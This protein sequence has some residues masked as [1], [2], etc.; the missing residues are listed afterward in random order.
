M[1]SSSAI[2]PDQDCDET[3]F[4]TWNCDALQFPVLL[5]VPHAGR[6]YPGAILSALRI[7]PT[8]LIRLEDR[9]ADRLA[10]PAIK[11]GFPAIIARRARAWIDLNRDESDLDPEMVEGWSLPKGHQGSAKMRGGLGLVP[12]RLSSFGEIWRR[13]FAKADIDE[14][15]SKY[16]RPYHCCIERILN[17]MHARFGV[18]ILI[19]LHSMPPLPASTVRQPQ[20]VIGD[21]FG[22]CAAPIYSELLSGR[23]RDLCYVTALNNPYPG[24]FI[25][26][27]HGRPGRNIHALQLEV[28]RRL[29]LDGLLQNPGSGL[30]KTAAMVAELLLLLAEELGRASPPL[31]A[32]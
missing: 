31:A 5:S 23:L 25:L 2:F 27:R 9:Y 29:Y 28:D 30:S 18:A 11:A 3:G 15:L 12:K 10:Q 26:R 24:D 1:Y 8:Y 20:I 14:R 16:H 7:D 6:D 32:E 17:A 13:P 21:R 4:S 22:Q 19:D